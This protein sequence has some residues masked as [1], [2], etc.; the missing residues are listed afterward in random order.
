M[1]TSSAAPA[2]CRRRAVVETQVVD[3][4][5]ATL[6]EDARERVWQR[7][8]TEFATVMSR[9]SGSSCSDAEVLVGAEKRTA[10]NATSRE[11]RTSTIAG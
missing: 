7:A 11:A 1:T 2:R 5:P 9:S 10:R 3:R 8:N 4:Q 6:R